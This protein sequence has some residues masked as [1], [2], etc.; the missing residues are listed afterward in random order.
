MRR[1][2]ASVKSGQSSRLVRKN[3]DPLPDARFAS[4]IAASTFGGSHTSVMCTGSRHA[5]GASSGARVSSALFVIVTLRAGRIAR[6]REYY[7][8][9]RAR[10]AAGLPPKSATTP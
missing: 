6:W 10:Q 2:C 4:S 3:G 5:S 8:E 1:R 9:G 7:D